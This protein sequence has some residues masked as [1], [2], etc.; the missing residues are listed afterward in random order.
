[1]STKGNPMVN[2]RLQPWMLKA[3]KHLS[4]Q[5]VRHRACDNEPGT[6][7]RSEIRHAVLLYLLSQAAAGELPME[8]IPQEER[9]RLETDWRPF[10]VESTR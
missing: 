2:V 9:W 1:M 3:I 5:E 10:A 6:G 8:F 7:P 4:A